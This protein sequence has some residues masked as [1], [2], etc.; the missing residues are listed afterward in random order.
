M[1]R[2]EIRRLVITM[3]VLFV[4]FVGLVE[5]LKPYAHEYFV[6]NNREAALIASPPGSTYPA[7]QA[8]ADTI[9]ERAKFSHSLAAVAHPYYD[10]S[11]EQFGCV[12]GFSFPFVSL[13]YQRRGRDVAQA[14]ESAV[15]AV[16]RHLA[17]F[18][19][20]GTKKSQ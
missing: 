5:V 9:V 6:S 18:A 10:A 11:F 3:T 12:V 19:Q 4:L 7:G 13:I 1:H 17:A 15:T 16:Q 14:C 20:A 8:I 2:A